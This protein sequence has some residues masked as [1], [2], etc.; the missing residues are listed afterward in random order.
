[1]IF[2]NHDRTILRH[3]ID[4]KVA[5]ASQPIQE[6]NRAMWVRLNRLE[7]VKPMVWI[8]E[9]C[10]PELAAE[11]ELKIQTRDPFCQQLETELRRELYQWHHFPA[12]MVVENIIYSP[13]VICDS[14]F[15]IEEHSKKIH[16]YDGAVASRQFEPTIKEEKDIEKIQMP[17]LTIDHEQT[18]QQ[19][20][21]RTDLFGDLIPIQKRGV[22]GRWFAP[23]DELIRW[24]GVQDALLDLVMRPEMVHAAMDRLVTAYLKRLDQW[25]TLSVLALNN[26]PI[27]VG[28]GGYGCTDELP[29]DSFDPS[30]IC[31]K[32]LWGCATAQIF[33]EVSPQMHE[34]F[35]L[36]YERR[37]LDRFG[38][39]YYGCCEPLHNK[40][41]ML[42]QIPNLRKI[43][44]SPWANVAKT[45][46]KTE[47]HYVISFKPNPAFLAEK[48]CDID[49]ACMY[50]QNAIEQANKCPM[51]IILKDISTIRF[52]PKRLSDWA[53]MASGITA[54]YVG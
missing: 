30:H 35:A 14:G 11:E 12:D 51:E 52:D 3:L 2:T 17:E 9:V 47:G 38:L 8:N 34:A 36:Q 39:V 53:K 5:I 32:D 13:I 22:P 25:E 40:I 20:A 41:D 44:T 27:R 28:S 48:T 23:W 10:W 49:A 6:K 54:Q 24:W 33:S 31:A 37:W 42:K 50:L 1:M 4:Q 45:A 7:P 43:S 19:L 15:G 26:T 46:E 18:E 21:W 29:P 16:A